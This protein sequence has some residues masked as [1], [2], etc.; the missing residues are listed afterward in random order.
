MPLVKWK[1]LVH[2]FWLQEGSV[3]IE[4]VN[5]AWWAVDAVNGGVI[6]VSIAGLVMTPQE[7]VSSEERAVS[8]S[9]L[10]PQ[11]CRART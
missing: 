11:N 8:E 5:D 2:L 9:S 1:H 3:E 4:P 6:M 7:D 10:G